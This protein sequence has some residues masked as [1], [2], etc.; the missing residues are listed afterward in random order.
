M[1][2]F[3]PGMHTK[4]DVPTWWGEGGGANQWAGRGLYSCTTGFHGNTYWSAVGL[5]LG[6]G[7]S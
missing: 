7:G 1:S 5:V 6:G 3:I 2:I 4:K